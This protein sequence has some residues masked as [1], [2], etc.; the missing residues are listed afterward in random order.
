MNFESRNPATGE[1]L[2]VYPEHDEVE[3]NTRLQRAWDG[4]RHWSRTPLKE[5]TAFLTRLAKLLDPRVGT[6]G[7]LITAEMG[8]PLGDAISEIEKS[9]MAARHFAEMGESYLRPQPVAGL[10]AQIMYE[11]L[12]PI[13]SIQPWNLPFLAGAALLQYCGIGRQHRYHQA[14]RDGAGF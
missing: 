1:L 12:G 13:L 4:W 2:A 6:Y 3:I 14:C 10:Q 9:A 8:K 5:R 7:R 11:S